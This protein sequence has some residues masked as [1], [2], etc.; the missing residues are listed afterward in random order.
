VSN[1]ISAPSGDSRPVAARA[2]KFRDPAVRRQLAEDAEKFPP[3]AAMKS[4]STLSGHTVVSTLA[5]QNRKYEGRRIGDIAAEEGREPIDVMLDLALADGLETVFLPD[6]GG[7]DRAS[8]ELRGRLWADDRTL[9]GASDAGAH[10]DL[11]DTF[12]FAATVLA[13]GVREQGIISLEAA[14]HQLTARPAAYFGLTDRGAICEGY[15]A[16]LVVFDPETVGCGPIE[17]RYDLPGGNA[18][19]LYAEALGI[20]HVLVNGVEIVRS[21]RHT[22]RLPGKLLRSGKDTHTVAL[23][24][25]RQEAA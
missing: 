2:E 1:I 19:R 22:G 20:D 7:D 24:A 25:L 10:L 15:H 11:S 14:I 17:R 12:D 6:Q 23:D 8:W 16:D 3:E 21:G 4:I 5:E 9:I 13:K 18:Y